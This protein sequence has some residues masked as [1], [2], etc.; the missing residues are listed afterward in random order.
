MSIVLKNI[1]LSRFFKACFMQQ[2]E[3]KT[4]TGSIKEISSAVKELIKGFEEKLSA[5]LRASK[6]TSS[7]TS[8]DDILISKYKVRDLERIPGFENKTEFITK[9]VRGNIK[10][11]EG[12]I[13]TYRDADEL[14]QKAV[15]E[16]LP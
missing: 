2:P 9:G 14:I 1:P 13:L 3:N 12:K 16:E 5:R 4:G 11:A 7:Y 15:D 10:K 8:L 6:F